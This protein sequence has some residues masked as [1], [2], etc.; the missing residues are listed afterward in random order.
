M[1]EQGTTHSSHITANGLTEYQISLT[2]CLLQ[3]MNEHPDAWPFREPV[4][5]RDVPDY[6]EIIKDPMGKG[7]IWV[8]HRYLFRLLHFTGFNL[9]IQPTHFSFIYLFIFPLN[10]YGT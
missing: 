6:Y 4:N 3:A 8:C 10:V 7:I 5:P 2:C 9:I 1:R